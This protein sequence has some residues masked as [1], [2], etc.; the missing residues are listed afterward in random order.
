M[1]RQSDR[2]VSRRALARGAAWSLPVVAFA[3]AAPAADASTTHQACSVTV[4]GAGVKQTKDKAVT[5]T[6]SAHNLGAA[7]TMTIVS[8]VGPANASWSAPSPASWTADSGQSSQDVIFSRGNNATGSA[9][10]TLLVCGRDVSL[11]VQ[12]DR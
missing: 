7:R 4:T 12:I 1:S 11:S 9:T 6:F 8:I 3:E 5:V 10:I 2:S